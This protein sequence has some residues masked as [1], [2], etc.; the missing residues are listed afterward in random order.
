MVELSH[1]QAF[2]LQAL[3]TEQDDPTLWE[4]ALRLHWLPPDHPNCLVDALRFDLGRRL[5]PGEQPFGAENEQLAKMRALVDIEEWCFERVDDRQLRVKPCLSAASPT[6]AFPG[7][8][9][10]GLM[11]GFGASV[12][13]VPIQTIFVYLGISRPSLGVEQAVVYSG[14]SAP[15]MGQGNAYLW[16]RQKDTGWQP[17][18]QRLAWWIT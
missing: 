15:G 12:P 3:L 1:I 10:S 8:G 11:A 17:T 5:M 13:A 4:A 2:G 16:V 7:T 6:F 18:D 14:S 9:L